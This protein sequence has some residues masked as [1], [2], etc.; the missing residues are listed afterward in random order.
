MRKGVEGGW[1]LKGCSYGGG[2][3]QCIAE[4][5]VG[6]N[7]LVEMGMCLESEQRVASEL[8]K[9]DIVSRGRRMPIFW[10]F[11]STCGE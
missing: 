5:E 6:V 2:L 7:G 11:T 4:N 10:D 1:V 3:R 8:G 9:P